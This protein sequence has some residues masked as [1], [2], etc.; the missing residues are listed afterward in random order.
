MIFTI[1]TK[2]TQRYSEDLRGTQSQSLSALCATL[3]ALC[4]EKI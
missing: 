2:V 3:C 1:G 4:G